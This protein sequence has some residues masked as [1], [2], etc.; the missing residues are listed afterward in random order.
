MWNSGTSE[1]IRYLGQYYAYDDNGNLI[2]QIWYEGDRV[3]DDWTW[4]W[5]QTATFDANGRLDEVLTYEWDAESNDWVYD[6]KTVYYW[7]KLT[8]SIS[9]NIIDPNYLIYPNPFTDYTTIK[10]SDAVQT[11]K[12]EL[13]DIHGRIVRTIENVNSNSVTIHRGNLPS[14]IYFITI[15]AKDTYVRK[16]IIR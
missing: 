4:G 11:Q 9:N 7:S 8:T 2:E 1:W 15:Q 12:I 5:R 10:L 6:S 14:G 13:I 3:T 16:V